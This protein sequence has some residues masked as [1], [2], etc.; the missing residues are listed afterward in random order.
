MVHGVAN[1]DYKGHLKRIFLEES[2]GRQIKIISTEHSFRWWCVVTGKNGRYA[3]S[4]TFNRRRASHHPKCDDATK[5]GRG[6]RKWSC[7]VSKTWKKIK[8]ITNLNSWSTVGSVLLNKFT[9]FVAIRNSVSLYYKFV[10]IGKWGMTDTNVVFVVS[11][12]N[13]Q[14]FNLLT[15]T[16]RQRFFS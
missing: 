14:K 15:M 3:W 13:D 8:I 7:S 12:L 10:Y 1:G 9:V 5:T 4:I 6:A 11:Q 2:V 16:K